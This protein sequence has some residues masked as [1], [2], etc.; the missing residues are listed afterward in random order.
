MPLSRR[1]LQAV[2]LWFGLG[3]LAGNAV[4]Q[5]AA[6]DV[7]A[8][9]AYLARAGDCVSC[10]TA[11]GGQPY[12]GGYKL[13]T[14]FGYLLSPN[15]T[16]DA[17]TGIGRWTADDFWRALHQGVNQR[18][19][20][21]YPVMPFDFYTRVT[22]EDSDAIFAYL[23]S[24]PAVRNAVVVNHLRFPFNQRWSMAVWRELYFSPGSHKPDPAKSA[25]WNRG[26]YL[27]EGLGHCSACHSPRNALGGI[28]K[29]KAYT[30]ATIDGWFA[31]NLTSEL[32][33]GLGSWTVEQIATYL[34]TGAVAGK[35]TALGPMA[36]VVKN[37]TSQMSEA[38][39]S[40]M[41]T[42]LKDIPANSTLRQ[43]KPAPDPT[44]AAGAALYLDHCA[45]CHQA[46]G[47]GMPGVF[48]PLAGNGVVLASDP[49]DILKVVLH[50]VPAQG[51]YVP[52]PAFAGQLNDQQVADLAN[53]LRT[54]WG[55]GAAANTTAAK[56]ARLRGATR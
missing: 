7:V 22:R 35:T 41:A 6:D 55:N 2:L 42:Y 38:D 36:L 34:K 54:S 23:R 5:T 37:S 21:M 19:Q 51:K 52:M 30:G 47:R 45:G 10:H 28:E 33:T 13:D 26:A 48:P 46:G 43:G 44:R 4:A 56:A 24:V 12:A 27:V 15:I 9:G 11:P 50:G 31:L 53:Y 20:D 39:L 14:P 25:T 32:H 8:R 3:L 17:V 49:A 1:H 16:P 29:D 40:A 18:G